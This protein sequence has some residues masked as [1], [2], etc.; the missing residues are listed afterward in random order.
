MN[1]EIKKQG[2][3]KPKQEHFRAKSRVSTLKNKEQSSGRVRLQIGPTHRPRS[4]SHPFERRGGLLLPDELQ[5]GR[6]RAATWPVRKPPKRKTNLRQTR[7]D[8]ARN[9]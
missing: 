5:Q 4:R 6:R 7:P 8:F 1:K 9:H 2:S 3:K